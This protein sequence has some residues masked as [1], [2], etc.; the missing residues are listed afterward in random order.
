LKNNYFLKHRKRAVQFAISFCIGLVLFSACEKDDFC[1]ENPVTPRLVI[2]FYDNIN[3]DIVKRVDRL[4]VSIE[5]ET[6]KEKIF[7]EFNTDSIAIPLNPT[8]FLSGEK[9]ATTYIFRTEDGNAS[10]KEA[11]L[12]IEYIPERDY[13]SRSCGFRIIFNDVE[14]T[15]TESAW[16]DEIDTENLTTV[17]NQNA[18]H[19]QI[20][21]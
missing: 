15:A 13:V 18:A 14:M 1:L 8:D 16:I 7:S 19:V 4:S 21:H 5:G 10:E 9:T 6:E 20:F 2:R 3:R 12:T 11:K 17:D